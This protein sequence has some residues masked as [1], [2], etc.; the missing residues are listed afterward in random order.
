MNNVTYQVKG[1]TISVTQPDGSMASCSL[2]WPIV[3]VLDFGGVLVLRIEPP[4]GTRFNENVYGILPNGT[5]GWQVPKRDYV[6]DDSPY[7]GLVRCDDKVK[8]MN[9][10]G[11]ELLVDPATGEE[12]DELYGR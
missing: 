11:L 9:W 8:L 3:Q 10:D 4:Q 2:P 12:L 7:T 1:A 5:I 6:Y